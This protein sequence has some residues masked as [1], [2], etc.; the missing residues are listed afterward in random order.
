MMTY[1][2]IASFLEPRRL[3]EPYAWVGHVPFA[4]W[5]M[6]QMRPK[7]L[8]ELGTHTGNSLC[9]FA[10]ASQVFEIGAQ[11]HAIDHW[12]GDSHAGI[13]SDDIYKE[14]SAY[15]DSNYPNDV[16]LMRASFDEAIHAF[17]DGTIDILHIDGM[18]TYEAVHHDFHTWLPK[19]SSSG[20]IL[21]HDTMVTA[22]DFGVH[23]LLS[24]IG[25]RY[26][27]VNFPHS[28]GL[29]VVAV[30]DIPRKLDPFFNLEEDESG[31]SPLTVFERLG[32]GLSAQA[33]VIDIALRNPSDKVAKIREDLH[34][35]QKILNESSIIL[36]RNIEATSS[37]LSPYTNTDRF[38]E[39]LIGTIL[40][41]GYFSPSF[42][43]AQSAIDKLT[44]RDLCRHYL[45]TGEACG[46]LPSPRFDPVHYVNRYPDVRDYPYGAL[47]H[48]IQ[49]GRLEGRSPTAE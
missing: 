35:I 34:G 23:R 15:V 31:L 21:L 46:L 27:T 5:L 33:H 3:V 14:L 20:I 19:L 44:D 2:N 26:R 10:Q 1:A 48:F 32:S 8:V 40:S 29:A 36:G 49:F 6:E 25:E 22:Q 9:A 42:Y 47:G 24:E 4:F 39:I 12:R 11:V 30:G 45:E 16:E 37:F 43:S 17:Q 7:K 41:S 18:H 13:Y 28:H 38:S